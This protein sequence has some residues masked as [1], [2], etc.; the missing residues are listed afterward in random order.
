MNYRKNEDGTYTA[1]KL[2]K[3]DNSMLEATA[4]DLDNAK[5]MLAEEIK[6]WKNYSLV[7]TNKLIF[8]PGAENGKAY[9]YARDTL[10]DIINKEHKE[11]TDGRTN[12]N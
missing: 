8:S 12:T 5:K 2:M 4:Q 3:F 6:A 11:E 1:F 9:I 10:V 7:E